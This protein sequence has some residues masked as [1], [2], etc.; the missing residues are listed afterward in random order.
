MTT[1]GHSSGSY[2]VATLSS[3]SDDDPSGRGNGIGSR[4][5]PP[6]LVLPFYSVNFYLPAA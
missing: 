3:D 4:R 6:L 5:K 2:L 1:S